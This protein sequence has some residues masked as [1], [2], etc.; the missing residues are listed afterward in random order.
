MKTFL[1]YMD[2]ATEAQARASGGP[3]TSPELVRRA[4]ERS[5]RSAAQ[6]NANQAMRDKASSDAKQK[7]DRAASDKKNIGPKR[8]PAGKP[9][10]YKFKPDTTTKKRFGPSI[11]DKDKKS[12]K[13]K[14]SLAGKAARAAWKVAKSALSS[15]GGSDNVASGG[16]FEGLKQAEDS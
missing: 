6:R 4:A 13:D 12:Y 11:L 7:A 10:Q 5:Q 14:K 3:N 15:K 2:E 16:N 1:Q 8:L 9:R